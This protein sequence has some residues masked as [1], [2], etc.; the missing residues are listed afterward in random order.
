MEPE[1][2]TMLSPHEFATLMLIHSA[3]DQIDMSRF[4]L[5]T[6]VDCQLISLEAVSGESHRP[7]LTPAG[8]HVL[9]VAARVQEARFGTGAQPEEDTLL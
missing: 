1:N 7:A 6:L 8:V 2:M 4:E 5:D 3:P 9:E